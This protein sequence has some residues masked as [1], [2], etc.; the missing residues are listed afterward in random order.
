MHVHCQFLVGCYLVCVQSVLQLCH[1]C[2][3]GNKEELLLLCDGCDTG[4]HTYCHKPKISTVP[5][6][7]WFCADC[8]CQVRK[9]A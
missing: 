9:T 7:E 8:E 3:K 6:G 5:D 1:F 2:K 4:Y